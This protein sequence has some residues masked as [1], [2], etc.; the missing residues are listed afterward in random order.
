MTEESHKSGALTLQDAVTKFAKTGGTVVICPGTYVLTEPLR[1]DGARSL[2]V[3]GAGY[4]T[5]LVSDGTAVTANAARYTRLQDVRVAAG[6]APVAVRLTDCL[7]VELRGVTV[8][9][10][11]TRDSGGERRDRAVRRRC[12]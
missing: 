12:C 7:G 1:L 6:R 11:Y 8:T 4:N 3:R 9:G 2:T 10:G 5:V